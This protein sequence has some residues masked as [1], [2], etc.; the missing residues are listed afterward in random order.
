MPALNVYENVILSVEL[1]GRKVDT[2]YVD[3]ALGLFGLS[4]KK[5]CYP[6]TLSGGQQQRMARLWVISRKKETSMF[7]NPNY[8]VIE[9]M[10]WNNLNANRRKTVILFLVVVFSLFDIYNSYSWKF[11]L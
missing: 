8:K 9:K 2:E 6:G 1:D 3:E 5:Q 11:L 7:K 10:G 4:E